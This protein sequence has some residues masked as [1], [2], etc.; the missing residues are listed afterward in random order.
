MK[1]QGSDVPFRHR[2]P[3]NNLPCRQTIP[4]LYSS[5]W[6]GP[7]TFQADR[8]NTSIAILPAHT[9]D[10]MVRDHT[11]DWDVIFNVSERVVDGSMTERGAAKEK[12]RD[13]IPAPRTDQLWNGDNW[14][15]SF[16]R[17]SFA[18]AM[19]LTATVYPTIATIVIPPIPIKSDGDR[20]K[21]KLHIRKVLGRLNHSAH[22]F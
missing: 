17:L 5:C 12:T 19:K 13:E 9:N 3:T 18:T 4:P 21:M 2:K 6:A 8:S 20:P 15:G 1:R 14:K 22:I 11:M 7:L 16:S 10:K